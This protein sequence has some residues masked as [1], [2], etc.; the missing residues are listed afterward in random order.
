MTT[1][2]PVLPRQI[3]PF[4][5]AII[6]VI[7][8]ASVWCQLTCHHVRQHIETL[9]TRIAAAKQTLDECRSIAEATIAKNHE[10][11][12]LMQ[13]ASAEPEVPLPPDED[14]VRVFNRRSRYDSLSWFTVPRDDWVLTI[15]VLDTSSKETT[16]YVYPLEAATVCRL[17]FY[18]DLQEDR[19]MPSLKMSFDVAADA[20]PPICETLPVAQILPLSPTRI[21]PDD[22]VELSLTDISDDALQVL[23]EQLKVI[24]T[25]CGWL[26][27]IPQGAFLTQQTEVHITASI[28]PVR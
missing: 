12:A 8:I 17:M 4:I 15:R 21:P 10:L 25:T 14:F 28:S 3:T 13:R 7:V 18:Y 1:R 26:H 5:W 22:R 9:D 16:D 11:S 6:V 19:K 24:V 20:K 27:P 23:K 2:A